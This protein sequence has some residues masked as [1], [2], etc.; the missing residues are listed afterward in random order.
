[1]RAY[2]KQLAEWQ[3][4]DSKL[5]STAFKDSKGFSGSTLQM[6]RGHRNKRFDPKLCK[7]TT[8]AQRVKDNNRK[9]DG[10]QRG[11][12]GFALTNYK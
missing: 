6:K 3:A 10:I 8:I 2:K 12:K 4:E 11:C 5:F 9:Y 1:M 7:E